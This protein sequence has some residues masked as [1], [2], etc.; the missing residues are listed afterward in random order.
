M[1]TQECETHT[2]THTLGI[3]E[4]GADTLQLISSPTNTD[5]GGKGR[6]GI[7]AGNSRSGRNINQEQAEIN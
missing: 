2:Q 5:I 4:V 7:Q 3:S 6:S 1:L